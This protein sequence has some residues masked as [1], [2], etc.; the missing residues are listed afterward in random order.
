MPTNRPRGPSLTV[1]AVWI[2]RGQLLLVRRRFPPFRGRWA[3]PGGF[4][5][6]GETVE[7]AVLRE[8]LEE[9]GL[10]ARS[11]SLLGVYSRPGRDP[12]RPTVSIAFR[13]RGPVSEPTGGSD[14]REAKWVPLRH[15]PRLAFDHDEMVTRARRRRH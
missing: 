4:V 11:V 8:L 14:A 12:R 2:S 6:T 7:S 1:D 9:T 5:E 3:L 13:V 10:R 15:L